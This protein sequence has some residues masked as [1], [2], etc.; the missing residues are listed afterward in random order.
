MRRMTGTNSKEFEAQETVVSQVVNFMNILVLWGEYRMQRTIRTQSASAFARDFVPWAPQWLAGEGDRSAVASHDTIHLSQITFR[1]S[2]LL[3][4]GTVI[5]VL[6][7][8]QLQDLLQH[9]MLS[10]TPRG[11]AAGRVR[12]MSRVR[13]GAQCLSSPEAFER[14]TNPEV[15]RGRG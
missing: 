12:D 6:R 11:V 7:A 9:L 15:Q 1:T 5:P 3:A 4:W 10:T 13:A 2:V 8:P 14:S